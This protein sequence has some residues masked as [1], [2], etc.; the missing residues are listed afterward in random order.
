[1]FLIKKSHDKTTSWANR[2]QWV[3]FIKEMITT[4]NYL[5]RGATGPDLATV[6]SFCLS[7]TLF[8]QYPSLVFT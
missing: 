7:A 3:A 6:S 4:A 8:L 5:A 1:M 2:A